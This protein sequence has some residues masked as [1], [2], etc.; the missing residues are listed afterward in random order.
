MASD[1]V[2][3]APQASSSADHDPRGHRKKGRAQSERGSGGAELS[4]ARA[5]IEELTAA[6]HQALLRGDRPEALAC[7]KKA[8]LASLQC[9]DS[10]AHRA[11]AFN[12][13]AAY[14]EAGKAQKGLEFLRRGS[15]AEGG[16]RR[17]D[18]HFNLGAAHEALGEAGQAAEHY[19]QAARLYREQEGEELSEADAW[20]KLAGCSLHS[21]DWAEAARG[22]QEAGRSYRAAGRP[23]S[24]AVA[25]REAGSYMLRSRA[26]S[27][28]D[29]LTALRGCWELGESVQDQRERGDLYN[30]VGLA[31]SQLKRFP[32][33]AAGF[34]RAL[35]LAGAEPRRRAVVLQN[36][37]AVHNALGEYP[38]ALE[39]HRQAASLHGSLGN[40]SAQGQCFSN[41]A[42]ALS[43][44]GEHEE[45]GECYL[46]ALQAFKDTGDCQGQWQA[47]E[48]LGAARFHQ[49]DP[50]KAT[51]H[52][53]QALALLSR[54]QDSP[55]SAQERIV[56]KL[57]DAIQ[58]KLSLRS[59]F[60]HGGGI[61]PTGPPQLVRGGKPM[62]RTGLNTYDGLI[63]RKPA[64]RM[65]H[66]K[67]PQPSPPDHRQAGAGRDIQELES[68]LKPREEPPEQLGA[69][70]PHP[71]STAPVP[72]SAPELNGEERLGREEAESDTL[73]VVTESETEL[74]DQPA[75][76][77]CY[78]TVA[79]ETNR[80]LNNTYLQPDHRYQNQLKDTLGPLQSSEHLYETLKLKTAEVNGEGPPARRLDASLGDEGY[81]QEVPAHR[82][83]RSR[84]CAVM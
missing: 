18:L 65:A 16:S 70:D 43:Q 12:L 83:S 23:E 54:C 35:P 42:F 80:N 50:E 8:F 63:L 39:Y 72:N 62:S 30:D 53:K 52:Y 59:R 76:G 11:C 57:A 69:A 33:A 45:A 13:G 60:S 22:F 48:G 51:V 75:G 28:E 79:T 81:S 38:Q 34:E 19:G 27:E 9:K 21:E 29:V 78:Q 3:V 82:K 40:R 24:A 47:S 10:R 58:Y 7:F 67:G 36:L 46:H 56:N 77:P 20:M 44:L 17:A 1:E 61:V 49:G 37:G 14:V 26:F 32:E 73:T 31:F 55:P 66:V 6:G 15:P 64:L 2:T 74:S 71:G 68:S 4:K 41:L 25:L 84:V 5:E